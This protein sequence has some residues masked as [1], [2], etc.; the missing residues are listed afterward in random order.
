MAPDRLLRLLLLL[1]PV[2]LAGC[3]YSFTGG[4]LPRHIR[5][6]AILPFENE[7]I[8]PLLAAEM[9]QALNDQLP[10]NL[11]V[12]LADERVAD[13]VVRGRIVRYEETA[14][15]VRPAPG[16]GRVDIIQQE[17]RI[18]FDAEILDLRERRILWQGR[19]QAALGTYQ[20]QQ[21][22][23]AAGRGRAI[24]EAV[25]RIIDGAQSQW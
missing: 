14:P 16:G 15:S 11:G 5:T 6:I 13:A 23:A 17:V 18:S 7:S 25:R 12:R 22:Q 19:G 3:L 20:P 2:V 10:R 21:E 24:Q 8:E 4:G 1:A 9:L